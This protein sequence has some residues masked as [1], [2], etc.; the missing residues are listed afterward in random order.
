MIHIKI[1]KNNTYVKNKTINYNKIKTLLIFYFF[2]LLSF[3]F[4]IGIEPVNN[5]VTVS[6]RQQRGSAIHTQIH[7][8]FSCFIL[9]NSEMIVE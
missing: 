9:F 6:G 1:I 5:V 7:V 3:L 4:C 8:C 2:S